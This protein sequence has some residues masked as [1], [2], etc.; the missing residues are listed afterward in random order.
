VPQLRIGFA[1]TP[2]FASHHLRRLID[3]SFVPVAIYTQP[4]RPSGRGKKLSPSPVKEL[5]LAN[6]IAVLQ[7][8]SLKTQEA[9]AQFALLKLDLLVVVAYGLILP[10]EILDA[11]TYGCINVHASLLPR[12]RGA[13]PIERALLAGDNETGVTIMEMDEGLD[14]GK[15]IHKVEIEITA[16]DTRQDLED[17]LVVAG[18]I[19]LLHT[20]NNLVSAKAGAEI[21][22]DSKATYAA[23]LNKAEALLCFMQSAQ[24]IDRVIRAGIGRLPAYCF[25]NTQRVRFLQAT[26]SSTQFNQPPGAIVSVSKDRVTV[27][28]HQSSLHITSIQLPGKNAVSIRDLHNSRPDYFRIG[29]LFLSTEA[30][31]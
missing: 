21:Q 3:T 2:D 16:T 26:P 12:W 11:P 5:A 23:K 1:G 20:L 10:A 17:K 14:T 13:A 28:C 7:P 30:A 19:G 18:G 9:Q 4:D 24:Q 31:K 27:A 22:D 25:Y 8:A 6:N 29:S 15:M